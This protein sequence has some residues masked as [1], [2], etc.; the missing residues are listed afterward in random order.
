MNVQEERGYFI[1]EGQGQ[2][3]GEDEEDGHA[4]G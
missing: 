4:G 2:P 1:S 3:Q